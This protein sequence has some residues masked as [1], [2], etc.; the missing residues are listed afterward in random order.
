MNKM[1]WE[2][3]SLLFEEP[4]EDYTFWDQ[5]DSSGGSVIVMMEEFCII[6]EKTNSYYPQHWN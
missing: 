1:R 5:L 6:I 3:F 2:D 4:D